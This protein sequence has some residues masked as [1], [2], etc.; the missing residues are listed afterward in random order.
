MICQSCNENKATTIVKAVVN[1]Q[2]RELNLC[3]HCAHEYGYNAIF[4]GI[5]IGD[6]L[7]GIFVNQA[8]RKLV[9]RCEKCGASF[10]EIA[11]T[12]K[13]GCAD[14]Y[15]QFKEQLAPMIHRIHGAAVHKGK[16][17]GGSALRIMDTENKIVPVKESAV[18]E[19]NRK[20]KAAIENQDFELAAKLRDEIKEMRENG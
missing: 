18:E 5:G 17:L 16:R 20:L 12:G 1:G 8:P 3:E 6:F 2:L 7:S 10:E 9:N 13:I 19:K 15:T 4:G 11:R 14:C